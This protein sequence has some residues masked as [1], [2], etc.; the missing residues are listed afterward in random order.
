MVAMLEHDGSLRIAWHADGFEAILVRGRFRPA[1]EL[2]EE[3]RRHG[4]GEG[5]V[6]GSDAGHAV[7][8]TAQE[9]VLRVA[10]F[11]ESEVVRVAVAVQGRRRYHSPKIHPADAV[12]G[13]ASCGRP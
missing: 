10:G 6:L 8:L 12:T 2:R 5:G 9:L 3:G 4:H 1:T 11:L 7:D 13:L